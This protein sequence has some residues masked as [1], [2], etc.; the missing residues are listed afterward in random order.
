MSLAPLRP[1]AALRAEP[2]GP[3]SRPAAGRATARRPGSC[4]PEA[5]GERRGGNPGTGPPTGFRSPVASAALPGAGSP[6]SAS[7]GTSGAST[8]FN[9]WNL[10]TEVAKKTAHLT[11]EG[12]GGGGRGLL[13]PRKP[14]I[15]K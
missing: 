11:G 4:S 14:R 8:A 3:S 13:L 6:G 9:V 12:G 1:S 5:A 2:A 10:G 15:V 7:S